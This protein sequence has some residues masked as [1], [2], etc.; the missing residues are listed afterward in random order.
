MFSA[1][2]PP[3]IYRGSSVNP[4]CSAGR[5][6]HPR[7]TRAAENSYFG[8]RALLFRRLPRLHR[9]R[10]LLVPDK[11]LE[12]VAHPVERVHP[13]LVDLGLVQVVGDHGELVVDIARAQ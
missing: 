6:P 13:V 9:G 4:A 11:S 1:A 10:I 2:V 3:R 8:G 5:E 12:E 7:A